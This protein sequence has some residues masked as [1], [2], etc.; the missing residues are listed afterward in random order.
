MEPGGD[1]S[2]PYFQLFYE[3]KDGAAQALMEQKIDFIYL[4]MEIIVEKYMELTMDHSN[5]FKCTA[6]GH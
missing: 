1:V 3:N 6:Q 2:D 4:V 5:N